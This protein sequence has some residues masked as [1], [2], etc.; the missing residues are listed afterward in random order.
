MSF[1]LLLMSIAASSSRNFSALKHKALRHKT[2]LFKAMI[3]HL[4]CAENPLRA[5]SF[6]KL[7]RLLYSESTLTRG[8]EE[9]EERNRIRIR[10]WLDDGNERRDKLLKGRE[11]QRR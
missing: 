2:W 11:G 7:F 6:R 1:R 5:I 8:R 3:L 10:R 4:K 9:A